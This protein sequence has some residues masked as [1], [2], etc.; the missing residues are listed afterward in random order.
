MKLSVSGYKSIVSKIEIDFPGL[1]VLAG[2]NSSGKSSFMQPFLLLKQT[3]ESNHDSG[4]LVLDGE[5]LRFTKS[6]QIFSKTKKKDNKFEIVFEENFVIYK[7]DK[8]GVV[9][10][11]SGIKNGVILSSQLNNKEIIQQLKKSPNINPDFLDM[12][13]K[14]EGEWTVI[15]EKGLLKARLMLGSFPLSI[16]HTGKLK[17][18]VE[19]LIHVPG[20]RGNPERFY[21]KTT[22]LSGWYPG[23]F[24]KYV[25]G[26][27]FSWRNKEKQKYKTLIQQLSKL[28]LVT[29]ID[30]NL[31]DDT[32]IE[33]QVSR[34]NSA[35]EE[36]S[37]NISDVGF[38]VS[39]TLP[40]LVALIAASEDQLVY[41][42]Q[43][44]LHLHPNAQFKLAEIIA[45][46]VNRGVQVVIETHSSLL[47]TGIQT[48]VAKGE[49]E[50]GKVSLN[51]FSQNP[52]NGETKV[53]QATLDENGAFGDWPEDFDDVT[54]RSEGAYLD[55][56]RK[57][58]YGK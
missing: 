6:S 56:V 49:L 55:A 8:K 51:W 24:D 9:A 31:I 28:G 22:S 40:V 34:F 15:Q 32:K 3:L 43:P 48:L 47:L 45:E 14:G 44:E 42:E 39:Q 17:D 2:A 7:D 38:G 1:T 10:S 25:A 58:A 23:L 19:H 33:I 26:I 12:I 21:R 4:A 57:R 46:A 11:L 5:N 54:L 35:I 30:S 29:H 50:S 13:E 27:V 18:F 41:I 37:V 36:D 52:E 53:D 16:E 20:L